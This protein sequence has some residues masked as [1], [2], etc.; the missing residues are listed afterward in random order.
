[1][2]QTPEWIWYPGDFEIYHHL[3]LNTRRE[4]RYH[5][6]PAFWR[7]DDCYHNVRFRK[8]V[9]CDHPEEITVYAHGVGHAWVDGIKYPF[10][11]PIPLTSGSHKLEISVART[12]GLPCIFVDGVQCA[13][14]STW[15]ANDYSIDWLPAGCNGLYRN[16]EDDPKVFFFQ[17][18]EI[19]PV[20]I[21]Q[22][23]NG[24]LYDYGKETF[25]QLAFENIQAAGDI[26]LNYG[27][28]IEEALDTEH[29]ILIDTV[30]AGNDS[31]RCPARAFRYL[32]VQGA[33]KGQFELTASYEY[34]PLEQ[35]GTFTCSN[36]QIN[37]IWEMAEYTLHLNS[38]EFFLDGI[39]R[40]RWVWSGDAYQSYLINNYIYF[41]PEITKRTIIALRGKDPIVRHIN[42]IMDYSFYWVMSIYDYYQTTRDIDFVAFIYPRM[43][44]MM[45]YCISRTDE[46]GFIRGREGDWVFIDWAEI[47]KT[48]AVCAEQMLYA[49]S[50]KAAW[51]CGELLGA[52]EERY[53]ASYKQ[54]KSRIDECFWDEELGAYIDSFESGK[55]NV[56]RH[57]NIFAL[58][59]EFADNEQRESIITNVLLNDEVPRISTPYFK[60]Y[61]LEVMCRI[62]RLDYV[63]AQIQSY[64]GGMIQ[65]DATTF[66]EEYNPDITGPERLGMYGDRYGKSLCHAWGASPIYLLGRYYFGVY[67]TSAG[68]E[69][70]A[71]E[72]QHGGLEWLKGTIPVNGGTVT[73]ALTQEVLEVISDRAG[74]TVR[75]NGLE[76]PL[77]KDIPFN[78]TLK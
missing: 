70:F 18:E 71:I 7:L 32:F 15:E 27:E 8:E 22:R 36:D 13:S 14:N 38:R 50:L 17:Y 23:E 9:L 33:E 28:S 58:L 21:E 61:E 55:R 74:G 69:T 64:W 45:E 10:G 44:S 42:T 19:Q 26:H 11:K 63:S 68:Y 29:S 52:G 57:A 1:M 6:W 40:D 62:G 67:P 3:L 73:V 2:L 65:L 77:L 49:E 54:L 46:D 53:L 43:K 47:D 37:R 60:F 76:Y 31:Y 16:K 5:Q 20:S 34:L 24:L 48:G 35:K 30:P 4:E 41:D 66:W 75:M 59:W 72:P 78:L 51:A 12:D 56:T 39:K 25:A